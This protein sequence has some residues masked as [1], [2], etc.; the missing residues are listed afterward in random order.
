MLPQNKQVKLR[1]RFLGR[2][3]RVVIG[4][5]ENYILWKENIRDCGQRRR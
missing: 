4:N 1:W 2:R 5:K 3:S